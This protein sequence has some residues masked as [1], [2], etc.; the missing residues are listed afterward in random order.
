QEGNEKEQGE[1]GFVTPSRSPPP[2]VKAVSSAG[3]DDMDVVE[4]AAPAGAAGEGGAK[5]TRALPSGSAEGSTMGRKAT[6]AKLTS[7]SFGKAAAGCGSEK[8]SKGKGKKP[9]PV[10]VAGASSR[11]TP[12]PPPPPHPQLEKYRQQLSRAVASANAADGGE[13]RQD[14]R[15]GLQDAVDGAVAWKSVDGD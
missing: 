4:V 5:E 6:T 9:T 3:E 1:E 15:M 11:P 10:A 8:G 14:R 7:S 13:D 2:P 12:P